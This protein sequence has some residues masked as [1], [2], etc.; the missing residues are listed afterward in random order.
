MNLDMTMKILL[1]SFGTRGDVQPYLALAVGLQRAGHQV[2]LSTSRTFSDWIHAYGVRTQPIRLSMQEV[3]QQPE[4]QAVLRSK[5][6]LR[7]ILLLR[8]VMGQSSEMADVVWHAA[9]D[10]DLIIQSPLGCGALEATAIRGIPA[11]MASPLPIAPTRHFPSFFLGSLRFSLGGGYNFFTHRLMHFMLWHGLSKHIINPLRRTLGLPRLRSFADLLAESRRLGVPWLYGYSPHVLPKPSDWDAQHHVTGYWFLAAP[12]EW[13][14]PTD[15]L[16]FLESGPPPIYIG[17]GSMG[18]GDPA[19]HTQLVLRALSLSG[20]RGVLLTGW[21]G[22]TPQSPPPNVFFVE[23]IPHDWLFPRMAAVVHHG[24]AGTT[25]AGLRAGV[26]NLITPFAPNDQVA[27]AERVE[28]L[29]VGIRL[30]GIKRLTAEQLA[31]AMQH[32]VTDSSLRTRAAALGETIGAE[33]G[34]ARAIE[35]IEMQHERV[36]FGKPLGALG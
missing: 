29:G 36:V 11:I 1:S 2:T 6:L 24:G 25:G 31:A 35:I 12:P 8:K 34:L 21:G 15:L 20:Q 14:P 22:L 4:V 32:A 9:Q 5:N 30:P 33:D 27:W 23:N 17:F 10:A 18:H 19:Q 28:R 3:M 16:H 7:Q 13:Q 26:P